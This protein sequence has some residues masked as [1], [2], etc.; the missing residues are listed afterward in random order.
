MT[1]AV[2]R[3]DKKVTGFP[4]RMTESHIKRAL[5]AVFATLKD[6]F[7]K[8]KYSFWMIKIESEKNL[9]YE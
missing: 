1:V 6:F 9:T 8:N 3:P 7:S 2:P 5:F 4:N